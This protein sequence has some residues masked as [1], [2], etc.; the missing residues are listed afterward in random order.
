[1]SD[2][3]FPAKHTTTTVTTSNTNVQT[4][5]RYDPLYAR[6]LPGLLKCFQ[7]VVDAIVFISVSCSKFSAQSFMSFM[8]AICGFGFWF[9]GILMMF[10]TFHIIEKFYKVPW[11]KIELVYCAL[12]SLFLMIGS[13]VCA[14]N[15]SADVTIGFVS[16]FGYLN[17]CAYG[18]DAFLKFRG[19]QDGEIAQGTREVTSKTTSN[20]DNTVAY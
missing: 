1:M 6:T 13:T 20:Q 16:F 3:E 15:L 11:L 12:W 9:T 4:N 17:M 14:P 10:Y 18:Y 8:S 2:P 7:L 5:I 19:V